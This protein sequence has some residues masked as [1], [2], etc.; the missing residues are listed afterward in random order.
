MY[1]YLCKSDSLHICTSFDVS[2]QET[3]VEITTNCIIDESF[4]SLGFSTRLILEHNII[5]PAPF[6]L[7]RTL[8]P[9]PS[10]SNTS[11]WL[12]LKLQEE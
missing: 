6:D 11:L 2:S 8:I 4:L 7:K 10:G 9:E 5:I 1:K 12:R 3:P